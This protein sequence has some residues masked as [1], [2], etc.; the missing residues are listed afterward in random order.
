LELELEAELAVDQILPK[1]T[2]YR[3]FF[4]GLCDTE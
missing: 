1:S 2:K 3:L 4:E